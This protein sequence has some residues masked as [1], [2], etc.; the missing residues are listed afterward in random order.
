[1]S[2]TMPSLRRTQALSPRE[3]LSS[4]DLHREATGPGFHIK[5][6]L[7]TR[8]HKD[9]NIYNDL[10]IRVVGGKKM[11]NGELSAFVN[12]VNQ[13]RHSQILGE[14]KEGD[15]VLE[16]NGV[17]LTGRTF[18]E[19]ERIVN[20]STGEIEI[21]LRTEGE[22]PRRSA[23]SSNTL[24]KYST[25]G[26]Y[27][28]I[29][30]YSHDQQPYHSYDQQQYSNHH[31]DTLPALRHRELSPERSPPVPM[32]RKCDTMGRSKS[33]GNRSRAIAY[34][35]QET[36]SCLGH[37]QVALSY[38]Q[39]TS[40]LLV[41][42]LSARGLKLRD[43]TQNILPNPFVK[44]Y[45]LPGRK[46]SHKRRTRFVQNSCD[47]EWNQE[48]YYDVPSTALHNHFLEFS[49]WDYDT[50]SEN[51][52][53]G[54][55]TIPLYERRILGGIARWYPIQPIDVRHKSAYNLPVERPTATN[56]ASYYNPSEFCLLLISYVT[57][58]LDIGYPAI[59]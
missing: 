8:R 9:H 53:L 28:R 2:G 58:T 47:P 59:N 48:V 11:P 33:S 44:I 6:I 52:A 42:I 4:F 10:G 50:F 14:I 18:E 12:G 41:Q 22:G 40:Q 57:C 25:A 38:N 56:N 45:L 3:A 37:L 21:I 51:N 39:S 5:R 7:L 36:D 46:V 19:V 17:L 34:G 30:G 55:V 24:Q 13:N 23:P 31:Y 16:W 1:M 15:E 20:S 35:R 43:S 29:E 26:R 32:H 49:I 27:N 54:Q